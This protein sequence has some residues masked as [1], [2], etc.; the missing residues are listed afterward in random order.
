MGGFDEVIDGKGPTH[1]GE[2]S[3]IT[4]R[5]GTGWGGSGSAEPNGHFL[6]RGLVSRDWPVGW[7]LR[8]KG[9]G[10]NTSLAH[11]VL[12][13]LFPPQDHEVTPVWQGCRE[14]ACGKPGSYETPSKRHYRSDGFSA[15]S[16]QLPVRVCGGPGEDLA[17]ELGQTGLLTMFHHASTQ[18]R[19]CLFVIPFHT[20]SW[21]HRGIWV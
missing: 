15:L 12:A 6:R 11:H 10:S 3:L 18:G 20:H 1:R 17:P 19:S 2:S 16:A 14:L 21:P 5:E 8:P 4:V 7:T 13:S 9:L